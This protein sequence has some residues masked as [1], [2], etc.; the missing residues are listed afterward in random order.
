[1]ILSKVSFILLECEVIS[2]DYIFFPTTRLYMKESN[3]I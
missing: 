3:N 1:M 2:I